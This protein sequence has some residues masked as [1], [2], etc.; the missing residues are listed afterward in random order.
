MPHINVVK[1]F[2]MKREKKVLIGIV[3]IGVVLV[4]MTY[5][6]AQELEGELASAKPAKV[7]VTVKASQSAPEVIF[8]SNVS[9]FAEYDSTWKNLPLNI[10]SIIAPPNLANETT[11]NFNFIANYNGGNSGLPGTNVDDDVSDR[12]LGNFST[13]TDERPIIKCKY[14]NIVSTYSKN[15]SCNVTLYY[16]DS[17]NPTVWTISVQINA[18]N[19][20]LGSEA[21]SALYSDVNKTQTFMIRNYTNWDML[22]DSVNWTTNPITSYGP[23]VEADNPINIINYGNIP[24]TSG[25]QW[26]MQ[27]IPY[28]LRG[29]VDISQYYGT[30]N[31]SAQETSPYCTG[32]IAFSDVEGN[33]NDVSFNL[34]IASSP[35][36]W[37]I[38]ELGFCALS[39]PIPPQTYSTS[40]TSSWE[41]Q[42]V[43]NGCQ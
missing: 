16:Y 9:F 8:V 22:P 1:H 29:E 35:S 31:F 30:S 3:L 21:G 19:R 26:K 41:I 5:F 6:I 12:V 38:K 36:V 11:L 17:P 32:A 34:G 43:C 39:A 15:Y 37:S 28:S 7:N 23:A 27:V 2:K 24:L 42:D 33:A 20:D 10:G 18:S 14:L 13:I 40:G 4:S 25:G